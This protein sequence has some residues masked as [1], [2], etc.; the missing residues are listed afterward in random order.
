MANYRKIMEL[1]LQGRSYNEIVEVAECSRRDIS[2]VKKTVT[3]L[4]ITIG[5]VVSMTDTD[6]QTLFP[7]GRK[8]V[9]EE[10]EAPDF[11]KVTPPTNRRHKTRDASVQPVVHTFL[12]VLETDAPEP[13][14]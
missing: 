2:V 12:H 6:I 9:S 4:G 8:R 14:H 3:A 11:A 5:S 10:Y 7:D 1:V 13:V